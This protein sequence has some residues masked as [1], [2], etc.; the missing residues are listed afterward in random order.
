MDKRIWKD[1]RAS[2]GKC[3]HCER[4]HIH[5]DSCL[6]LNG[7]DDRPIAYA[8]SFENDGTDPDMGVPPYLGGL[9]P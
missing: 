1:E 2:D 3:I 8:G 5:K 9:D 7:R 6:F 4:R